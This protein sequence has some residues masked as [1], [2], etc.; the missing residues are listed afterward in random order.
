MP[1]QGLLSVAMAGGTDPSPPPLQFLSVTEVAGELNVSKIQVRTL[2]ANGTLPA[3]RT[4][5]GGLR[6][7]RLMLERWIQDRYAETR[8]V[9]TAHP[10]PPPE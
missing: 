1:T 5:G 4:D 9:T 8:A 3:Q 7:E 6:V 2:I 10:W